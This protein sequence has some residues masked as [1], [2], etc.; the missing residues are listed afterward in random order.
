MESKRQAHDRG[1][2][3]FKS[4]PIKWNQTENVFF[5]AHKVKILGTTSCEIL[6]LVDNS[7]GGVRKWRVESPWSAGLQ[8]KKGWKNKKTH[9][10]K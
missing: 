6:G 9:E 10:I 8:A 1:I 4:S 7:W 5:G 3:I 2:Y